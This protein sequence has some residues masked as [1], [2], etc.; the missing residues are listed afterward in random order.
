MTAFRQSA[1]RIATWLSVM[2]TLTVLH[3][4]LLAAHQGQPGSWIELCTPQG[5]LWVNLGGDAAQDEPPLGAAAGD[6]GTHCPLCRVFVDQAVDFH[7]HELSFSR[8]AEPVLVVPPL[9]PP[10]RLN[11]DPV[12]SALAPRAPP[13]FPI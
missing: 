4:T 13:P 9:P 5:V 8:P 7:R 10:P 3:S 11:E 6:A 12:A 2:F 1:R